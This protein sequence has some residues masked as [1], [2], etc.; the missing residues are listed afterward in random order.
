MCFVNWNVLCTITS[1]LPC[2]RQLYLQQTVLCIEHHVQCLAKIMQFCGVHL[3]QMLSELLQLWGK[4]VYMSGERLERRL[5][6]STRE[7][8]FRCGLTLWALQ[9][10]HCTHFSLQTLK[11]CLSNVI[12]DTHSRNCDKVKKFHC[13]R[14]VVSIYCWI[15]VAK[16]GQLCFVGVVV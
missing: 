1:A 16:P 9:T 14:R 12:P 3:L 13:N 15:F 10:V 5:L 4:L 8:C 6:P 2:K 7:N 11:L